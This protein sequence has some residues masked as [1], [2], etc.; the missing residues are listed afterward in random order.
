MLAFAGTV[1]DFALA[2][3]A[4]GIFQ[5]VMGLALVQPDMGASA[6]VRVEHPIDDEERAL[7]AADF[8][9]RRGEIML[10]RIGSELAQQLARRDGPLPDST[11]LHAWAV[12]TN[13]LSQLP[14]ARRRTRPD[15][16][17]TLKQFLSS[18]GDR[19]FIPRGIPM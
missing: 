10:A 14:F 6:H 12:Q 8:A 18:L 13:L 3:D 17:R 15:P 7:D 19:L 4:Q 2:S 9:K 1:T 5:G 11:S 16:Y